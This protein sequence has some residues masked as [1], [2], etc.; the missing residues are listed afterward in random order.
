MRTSASP[1]LRPAALRMSREETSSTRDSRTSGEKP[2]R[3]LA[4]RVSQEAWSVSTATAV[5]NPAAWKPRSRPPAPVNKEMTVGFFTEPRPYQ[6][7]LSS[8]TTFPRYSS[9]PLRAGVRACEKSDDSRCYPV[10][11]RGD[12]RFPHPKNPP[13]G[14][15]Q[16][17]IGPSI[18][19]H[20]STDLSGPVVSV[21]PLGEFLQADRQLSPVPKVTVTE[22]RQTGSREDDIR[23]TRQ[24]CDVDSIPQSFRPEGTAEQKL[25]VRVALSARGARGLARK[26]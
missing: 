10:R 18:T 17:C 14:A 20:I 6:T 9:P 11:I 5:R 1:F 26:R 8:S 24:A 22:N 23:P 4:R 25:R 7:D 19:F 12:V 15:G 2:R 13:S 21:V 16:D 3:L